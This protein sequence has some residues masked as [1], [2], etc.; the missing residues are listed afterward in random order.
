MHYLIKDDIIIYLQFWILHNMIGGVQIRMPARD[1]V[2]RDL[3]AVR[4]LVE[5]PCPE[6]TGGFRS[7]DFSRW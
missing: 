4:H 5:F 7:L 2:P 1:P 3:E 6:L